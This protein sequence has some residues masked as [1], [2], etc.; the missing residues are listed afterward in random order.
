MYNDYTM[1]EDEMKELFK[2]ACSYVR[3]TSGTLRSDDLLYFYARYKQVVN[4]DA[5]PSK[6]KQRCVM[7]ICASMPSLCKRKIS[8]AKVQ[9]YY[10]VIIRIYLTSVPD[11]G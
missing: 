7:G 1:A 9:L 4:S 6:A 2:N 10:N 3:T 8:S 5:I 11:P